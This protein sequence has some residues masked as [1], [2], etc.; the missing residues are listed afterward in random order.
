MSIENLI[1][2]EHAKFK[3]YCKILAELDN[4]QIIEC[5]T[6]LLA[7]G[8]YRQWKEDIH[9]DGVGYYQVYINQYIEDDSIKIKDLEYYKTDVKMD[10]QPK[11]K[12]LI[13]L[14]DEAE[15][16]ITNLWK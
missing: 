15:W 2:K 12:K 4:G 9:P 1:E 8:S 14:L 6:Y 16:E 11:I 3:S 7:E 10:K 5:K 13:K